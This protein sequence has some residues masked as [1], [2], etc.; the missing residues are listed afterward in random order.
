MKTYVIDDLELRDPTSIDWALAFARFLARETPVNSVFPAHSLED[1]EWVAMLETTARAQG[2]IS[3]YLPHEAVAVKIL[4][5]PTY[6]LSVTEEGYS[7][8]FR[9]PEALAAY[10]RT[11]YGRNFADLYPELPRPASIGTGF[12][13][14]RF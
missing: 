3:Y 6:A 14:I 5:D 8:T 11:E 7:G 4:T 10:L 13:R 1:E 2:G 9:S 12:D